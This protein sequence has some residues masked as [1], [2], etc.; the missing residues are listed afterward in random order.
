MRSSDLEMLGLSDGATKEEIKKAYRENA[1]KYHPD[2]NKDLNAAGIFKRIQIAYENLMKNEDDNDYNDKEEFDRNSKPN[3][4]QKPFSKKYNELKLF[5]N[6]M[7]IMIFD[8]QTRIENVKKRYLD[9]RVIILSFIVVI[10]FCSIYIFIPEFLNK[11]EAT[12][13]A[14]HPTSNLNVE[15]LLIY[16]KANTNTF[17]LDSTPEEIELSI[18][19]P[20]NYNSLSDTTKEIQFAGCSLVY[21]TEIE[22]FISFNLLEVTE[23]NDLGNEAIKTC[24]IKYSGVK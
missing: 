6:T 24:N 9:K 13:Q 19:F 4:S 21:D 8:N 5:I 1:K 23:G 22:A 20:Y 3:F 18:G 17:N 10:L 14:N 16:R 11:T 15:E 7:N 12:F 2:M